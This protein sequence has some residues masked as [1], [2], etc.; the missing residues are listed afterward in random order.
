MYGNIDGYWSQF[1]AEEEFEK[2]S[3]ETQIADMLHRRSRK[4]CYQIQ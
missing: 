1:K 3:C 4:Q 2:T